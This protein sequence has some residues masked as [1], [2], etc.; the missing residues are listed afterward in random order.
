MLDFKDMELIDLLLFKLPW[1]CHG[2]P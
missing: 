2:K 1:L